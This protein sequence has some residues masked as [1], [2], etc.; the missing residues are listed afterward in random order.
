MTMMKHAQS[1]CSPSLDEVQIRPSP[2]RPFDVAG[3]PSR[4]PLV[5]CDICGRKFNPANLER[6]TTICERLA[7]KPKREA[8]QAIAQRLAHVAQ[9]DAIRPVIR[10][11]L[12]KQSADEDGS[13]MSKGLPVNK[14]RQPPRAERPEVKAKE[15][16]AGHSRCEYCERTFREKAYERHVDFCKQQYEI[17]LRKQAS[18]ENPQSVLL[19]RRMKY[20]P[21]PPKSHRKAVSAF[22]SQHVTRA[23]KEGTGKIASSQSAMAKLNATP[24]VKKVP[25]KPKGFVTPSVYAQKPREKKL[26]DD[27]GVGDAVLS[28]TSTPAMFKSTAS[29]ASFGCAETLIR[30]ASLRMKSQNNGQLKDAFIRERSN[31]PVALPKETVIDMNARKPG[32]NNSVFIQ[33]D[34]R[35][36]HSV[37]SLRKTDFHKLPA[38]PSPPANLT[39]KV[40]SV[41]MGH[42]RPYPFNVASQQKERMMQLHRSNSVKAK[43][44]SVGTIN[45]DW[46]SFLKPAALRNTTNSRP[47]NLRFFQ[48]DGDRL[49]APTDQ[50]NLTK[51]PDDLTEN[52]R[53]FTTNSLDGRLPLLSP[54]PL[55]ERRH[56]AYKLP[57]S[58]EESVEDAYLTSESNS[59]LSP[60]GS[61]G[62]IKSSAIGSFA[63]VKSSAIGSLSSFS[64]GIPASNYPTITTKLPSIPHFCHNCGK[65]FPIEEA[66][67]C[68]HC[69]M[70]RLVN[71]TE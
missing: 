39:H 1:P 15:I 51:I 25:T 22:S 21:P 38:T 30:T 46:D 6:H 32:A 34:E 8:F 27:L 68:C 48:W 3:S 33:M 56:N 26:Y 66:A 7:Q 13:A 16:P 2:Q 62:S 40:Q 24:N 4:E 31:N 61:M 54:S 9:E 42:D 57:V 71:L 29:P 65:R 19:M 45:V 50:D 64:S 10:E 47:D 36:F 17:K 18:G 58:H 41:A 69:G 12:E 55:M 20:R 5:P 60:P 63:S 53:N 67:F 44:A 23:N 43:S 35:A 49:R 59:P 37:E 14:K 28:K 70:K 52:F 11:N